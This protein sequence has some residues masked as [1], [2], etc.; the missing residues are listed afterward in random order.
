LEQN[1][2]PP[3]TTCSTFVASLASLWIRPFTSGIY[4][5]R[6]KVNHFLSNPSNEIKGT[7][8]DQWPKLA[9]FPFND[10]NNHGSIPKNHVKGKELQQK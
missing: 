1:S 9:F 10:Q 8:D 4:E 3:E 6:W 2:S 7:T 5:R